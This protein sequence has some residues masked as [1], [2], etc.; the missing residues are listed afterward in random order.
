MF[1]SPW[2]GVPASYPLWDHALAPEPLSLARD[3]LKKKNHFFGSDA[4]RR[5][6]APRHE[7]RPCRLSGCRGDAHTVRAGRR[8]AAPRRAAVALV[9]S[10]SSELGSGH[11]DPCAGLTA[12][13]TTAKTRSPRASTRVRLRQVVTRDLRTRPTSPP[14]VVPCATR[15]VPASSV[16]RLILAEYSLLQDEQ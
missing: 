7:H 15:T 14:S 8:D 9:L 2:P 3:A 4:A 13:I 5:D 10:P 12:S 6:A 11:G 16:A 1:L